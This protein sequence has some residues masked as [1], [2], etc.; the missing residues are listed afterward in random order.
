M[1]AGFQAQGMVE[2][3]REGGVVN[4]TDDRL[5]K[6]IVYLAETDEPC[7]SLKA[8][9]ERAEYKAKATRDAVFKHSDGTVADRTA[10]AG[11]SGEYADAMK[12]YFDTLHRYEA[13]RN[14]RAT[15]CIVIDVWRS[16]QANQRRGNI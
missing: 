7:A 8:D 2:E 1:A 9:T 11:S 10:I 15:E 13:M 12:D 3:S 14:K 16:I 6:A 5:Q 4:I